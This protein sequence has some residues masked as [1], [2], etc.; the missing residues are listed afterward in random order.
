MEIHGNVKSQI[1]TRKLS[2]GKEYITGKVPEKKKNGRRKHI[3]NVYT[4]RRV[5]QALGDDSLTQKY[6][7]DIFWLFWKC[8]VVYLLF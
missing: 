5:Q 8:E 3:Q 6:K 1:T 4:R 2:S 7:Y